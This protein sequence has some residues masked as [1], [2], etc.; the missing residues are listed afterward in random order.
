MRYARRQARKWRGYRERREEVMFKLPGLQRYPVLN[1][2]D[3]IYV[4]I[5]EGVRYPEVIIYFFDPNSRDMSLR[6]ADK[7]DR[8]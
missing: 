8:E 5:S 4:A 3:A 2:E 7:E 1:Y 6:I